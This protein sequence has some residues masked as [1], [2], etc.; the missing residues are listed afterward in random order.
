M[1]RWAFLLRPQWLALIVLVIA[2]A[3]LCFTVLAP[4]QLGKNARTSKQNAQISASLSA[5]PVPVTS[6]LPEQDSSAPEEQWRRVTATG[7]YLPDAQLLA[8]LRV[9]EGEPAFEVLV[10]FVVDGGPTVLVDRGYVRPVGGSGVPSIPP[11]PDGTVTIEARLRDSEG[12]ADKEPLE[13]N[14]TRQVY[15]IHVPQIA[16][17]TGVPLAGSYL[18]L[19]ENQ[20]GVLTPMPLPHL[21]A[22]PFLSYGMQWIAFG[23]IAPIGL[24]YF[25]YAEVQQRRRE[26]AADDKAAASPDVPLTTEE[27][28]ADRYG[29]RR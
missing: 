20:P 7:H 8:R 23:I 18:Q 15:S 11:V 16:E 6:L 27:K 24:G 10:P 29:R 22:G 4:W 25:V 21:D 12:L 5:D 9:I 14:G 13:E 28:L 17:L 3:Y 26:K 19:S 1:R 2:F